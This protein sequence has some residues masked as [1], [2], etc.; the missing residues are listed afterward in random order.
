MSRVE[1]LLINWGA[2]WVPTIDL[3]LLFNEIYLKYPSY[4][5]ILPYS[6]NWHLRVYCRLLYEMNVTKIISKNVV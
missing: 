6:F 2:K 3:V 4:S 5:F 1:N